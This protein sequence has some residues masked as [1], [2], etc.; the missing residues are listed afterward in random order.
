MRR[1]S[2]LG[3]CS[4]NSLQR[5]RGRLKIKI[6]NVKFWLKR[7][8]FRKKTKAWLNLVELIKICSNLLLCFFTVPLFIG[9]ENMRRKPKRVVGKRPRKWQKNSSWEKSEGNPSIGRP[10]GQPPTVEFPTVGDSGRPVGWPFFLTREQSSLSVGRGGRP[11][12]TESKAFAIGRPHGR[13]KCT[14]CT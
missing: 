9:D 12:P 7:K 10:T 14:Q 4:G 11:G 6:K 5:C 2:S 3:W 1:W 8:S 13:P